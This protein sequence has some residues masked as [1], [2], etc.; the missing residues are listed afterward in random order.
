ML[1]LSK[2]FNLSLHGNLSEINKK[3]KG[4][5]MYLEITVGLKIIHL[6]NIL[7]YSII[8][9][10][11]FSLFHRFL[12]NEAYI[13]LVILIRI[14]LHKSDMIRFCVSL[15]YLALHK[16]LASPSLPQNSMFWKNNCFAV[17]HSFMYWLALAVPHDV[18]Y[19]YNHLVAIWARISM[20]VLIRKSWYRLLT[21]HSA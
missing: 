17:S 14:T 18:S 8:V 15:G 19:C 5:N 11:L 7:F 1:V 6:H 13:S 20:M 2:P 16:N 12:R 4:G 21:D 10:I 9:Q 3:Q